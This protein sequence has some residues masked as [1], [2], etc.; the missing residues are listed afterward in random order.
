MGAI[1]SVLLAGS[2]SA[3]PA[4]AVD[5]IGDLGGSRAVGN[6][7]LNLDC[8]FAGSQARRLRRA[9]P[10]D[11]VVRRRSPVRTVYERP[12]ARI[13]VDDYRDTWDIDEVV[14]ESRPVYVRTYSEAPGWDWCPLN[15]LFG[16][17]W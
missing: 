3:Q 17:R 2:A 15:W 5:C 8:E 7:R 11:R 16:D 12:R 13:L 6:V 4:R 10:P 1:A 9:P 14:V